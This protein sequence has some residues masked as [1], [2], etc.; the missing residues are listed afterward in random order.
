[1]GIVTDSYGRR[2]D[3]EWNTDRDFDE[4]ALFAVEKQGREMTCICHRDFA[5]IIVDEADENRCKV[6][7]RTD[8]DLSRSHLKNSRRTVAK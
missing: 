3:P 5:P 4:F 6:P 8:T 7:V 2:A 1:M